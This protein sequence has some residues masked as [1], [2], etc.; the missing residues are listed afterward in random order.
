MKDLSGKVALITG[1]GRPGCL[2]EAIARRFCEEGA[3]VVLTD[4]GQP[5]G[6]Y[7]TKDSIGSAEDLQSTADALAAETRGVVVPMTCDVRREEE[8]QQCVAATVARFGRLDI[9]ATARP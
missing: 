8:I 9:L 5:S 4:I 2:G 3:S 7:L 1:A 6:S